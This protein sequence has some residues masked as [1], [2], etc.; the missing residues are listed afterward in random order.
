MKGFITPTVIS[1]QE[2]VN[3]M[4]H[5]SVLL[6][7]R[8][9]TL[10]LIAFPRQVSRSVILNKHAV[11]RHIKPRLREFSIRRGQSNLSIFLIFVSWEEKDYYRVVSVG[12]LRRGFS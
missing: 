9:A 11:L 1:G 2:N 7:W 8:S 6:T 10:Y 5:F 4:A 3:G 12:Q